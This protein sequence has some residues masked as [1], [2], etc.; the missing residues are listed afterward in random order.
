MVPSSSSTG[1]SFD[2]S[3]FKG[4]L[5]DGSHEEFVYFSSYVNALNVAQSPIN[6]R[7]ESNVALLF[8]KI[9]KKFSNFFLTSLTNLTP[10]RETAL[11]AVWPEFHQEIH[12]TLC[13]KFFLP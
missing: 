6:A 3:N 2:N 10:L 1:S 13:S 5:L 9:S 4:P 7:L 11:T 12:G 8:G